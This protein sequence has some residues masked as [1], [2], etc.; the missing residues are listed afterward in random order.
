MQNIEILLVMNDVYDSFLMSV[1]FACNFHSN[2]VF[3]NNTMKYYIR[4]YVDLELR[5]FL[6]CIKLGT[7]FDR[8]MGM[9][10][11]SAP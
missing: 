11:L 4:K 7:F 9:S 3:V 1:M 8:C 2:S 5:I 10:K 6:T